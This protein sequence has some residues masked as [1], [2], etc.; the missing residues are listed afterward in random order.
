MK[1]VPL[2]Y[3]ITRS[4]NPEHIDKHGKFKKLYDGKLTPN[5]AQLSDTVTSQ[6]PSLSLVEATRAI[7]TID[8][9]AFIPEDTIVVVDT[10]SIESYNEMSILMS[11]I[12]VP[13]FTV[14]SDVGFG[15]FYFTPTEY[16]LQSPAFHTSRKDLGDIDLMQGKSFV[17]GFGEGNSTKIAPTTL[18]L[19]NSQPIPN[20]VVDY[21]VSKMATQEP[22]RKYSDSQLNV[23]YIGRALGAALDTVELMQD[24]KSKEY[25]SIEL[26]EPFH[27]IANFLIPNKFKQQMDESMFYHPDTLAHDASASGFVQSSVSKMLRDPSISYALGMSYLTLITTELWSEPISLEQLQGYTKNYK[28]QEFHGV[29]YA[30]DPNIMEAETGPLLVSLNNG[31]YGKL[32][33][34]ATDGFMVE[35]PDELVNMGKWASFKLGMLTVGNSYAVPI[36]KDP[37]KYAQE[38][39]KAKLPIQ[40]AHRLQRVA[41]V[42]DI[43]KSYG[44]DMNHAVPLYNTFS[45]T[46]YNNIILGVEPEPSATIMDFPDIRDLFYN[47]VADHSPEEQY[48]LFRQFLFLLKQKA[49][50]AIYC[51]LLFQ[52]NG[53]EG[54]GKGVFVDMLAELFGGK[55]VL[56]VEKPNKHHN[57]ESEN[58]MITQQSEL[59]VS[60]KN[61]DLLK[62]KTGNATKMVEPKGVD[63]YS[64]RN[65]ETVFVETNGT[66]VFEDERRVVLL[67]S[68][69]GKPWEYTK[70][71]PR[72]ALQ[73]RRMCAYIRDIDNKDFNPQVLEHAS[74]WNGETYKN[75]KD[76]MRTS[77]GRDTF[78]EVL[79]AYTHYKTMSG[80]E[81]AARLENILGSNYWHELKPKTNE[82]WLILQSKGQLKEGMEAG[83]YI[84][85]PQLISKGLKQ[86]EPRMPP[87]DIGRDTNHNKNKE[88]LYSKVP[89]YLRFRL[90]PTQFSEFDTQETTYMPSIVA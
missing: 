22:T 88:S 79:D 49:I 9:F 6:L 1:I 70:R 27:H 24:S 32:Y 66:D 18:T 35:A 21:L 55:F 44:L 87:N 8:S 48:K 34:S 86:D 12:E 82:L 54:V 51:S 33:L 5:S 59:T 3:S 74:Y 71:A 15:H 13:T 2:N 56:D 37:T 72:V 46:T 75:A 16:Y 89:I 45:R 14:M 4:S 23:T 26:W 38:L 10:D 41:L 7:A 60:T 11:A 76:I 64:A 30:Y 80:S 62:N 61:W 65:V 42:T 57:A 85:A 43:T 77:T 68:F 47:L 73:M 31:P 29:R 40:I 58:M 78:L 36:T 25:S 39:A 90:T 17:W 81:V 19:S 28:D 53:K 83:Y 67:Q 84:T 52:L 50:G 20:T 63:A 69:T